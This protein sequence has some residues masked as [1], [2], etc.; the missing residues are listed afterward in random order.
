MLVAIPITIGMQGLFTGFVTTRI[1]GHWFVLIRQM[2]GLVRHAL[3]E[4]CTVPALL[5]I[6]FSAF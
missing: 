3:A 5:L 4:V 1:Y 2:A 6:A